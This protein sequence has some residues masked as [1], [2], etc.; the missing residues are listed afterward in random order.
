[1]S[2]PQSSEK[3]AQPPAESQTVQ[4]LARDTQQ[5]QSHAQ[6]PQLLQ[7][8][9]S[10]QTPSQSQGQTQ[11]QTQQTPATGLTGK[12]PLVVVAGI[13]GNQGCAVGCALA[14][15]KHFAVRGFTIHTEAPEVNVVENRNVEVVK[16][17]FYDPGSLD[18]AFSG[19]D[20]AFI[21]TVPTW[22]AEDSENKE[23]AQGK[24]MIDA[25]KKAGVKHVLFTSY[26][27]A[28]KISDGKVKLPH[29][30]S[31][32]RIEEYLKASGLAYTIC[33][34]PFFFENFIAS[35]P[36]CK[37]GDNQYCIKLPI[38]ENFRLPM[39]SAI[40]IGVMAYHIFAQPQKYLGKEINLATESLTIADM[41][42]KM[43]GALLKDITGKSVSRAEW[44][45]AHKSRM[46]ADQL[47]DQFEFVVEYADKITP[48]QAAT[49]ELM[50]PNVLRTFAAWCMEFK[51]AV[52]MDCCA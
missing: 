22:G 30:D 27:Y 28:S 35:T 31:K 17:D 15:S 5:Q 21:M 49:K 12:E 45:A 8:Q 20:Y 50:E 6:Q 18:K 38:P 40:D 29:F 13:N 43:K 16:A 42:Q 1:M 23:F 7:P 36:P 44:V 32:G 51:H 25:C 10:Q 39:I 48:D 14:N 41:A 52:K 24:N 33:R 4:Q 11:T 46:H 47:V 19:A 37:V 2:Q 9:Q 26:P 34:L 3:T